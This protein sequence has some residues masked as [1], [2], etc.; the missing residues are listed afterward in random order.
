MRKGMGDR[1][2]QSGG[3]RL[4][5]AFLLNCHAV[6]VCLPRDI[7]L[8]ALLYLCILSLN[9]KLPILGLNL[10]SSSLTAGI[11][12]N[13]YLIKT[14]WRINQ[15][16]LQEWMSG[17]VKPVHYKAMNMN[18]AMKTHCLFWTMTMFWSYCGMDRVWKCRWGSC[19]EL[20][21]PWILICHCKEAY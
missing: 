4:G 21:Q 3:S 13:S 12:L 9:F 17:Q 14:E 1:S 6:Y 8:S 5:T 15:L 7:I 19:E 11:T 18:E 10:I 16:S 20:S 2:I